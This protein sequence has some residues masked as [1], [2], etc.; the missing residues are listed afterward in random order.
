MIYKFDKEEQESI[1]EITPI[2]NEVLIDIVNIRIIS[3]IGVAEIDINKDDV[4]KLIGALHMLH[5][6]MK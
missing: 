3:S 6:E 4:Y 2:F 1:L 5:K